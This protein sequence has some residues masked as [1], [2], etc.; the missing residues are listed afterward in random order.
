MNDVGK[1]APIL[2]ELSRQIA[3]VRDIALSEIT[4]HKAKRVLLDTVGVGLFGSR[5]D[6]YDRASRASLSEYAPGKCPMWGHPK[7]LGAEGAV[8]FNSLAASALDY[9]DGHVAAAGHPASLVVP[10]ATAVGREVGSGFGALLSAITIGYEVGT[11]FSAARDFS[12]VDTSSSGRWGALAS[13]TAAAV[14]LGL[15]EGQ[16]V[17]KEELS[18]FVILGC[19]GRLIQDARL[20]LF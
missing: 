13:A 18:F 5:T 2:Y 14:L 16:I 12:K 10:T 4:V 8:F 6:L 1:Q 3:R 17:T 9:D 7:S 11:R 15:D 20:R 19:K